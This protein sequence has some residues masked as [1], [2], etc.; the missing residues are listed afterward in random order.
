VG[1]EVVEAITGFFNSSSL[2]REVN[3][4]IISL[5]PK[6]VNPSAMGDFKPIACCNVIYK[7]ITRILSNRMLPFLS[8]LVS[9]NQFAFISARSISENVL[10]AQELVG[11]YHKEKGNPRCT[12]KI[13]FIK[14]YDFVN[15]EFILHCLHCF[16]FPKIFLG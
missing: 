11:G 1:Q 8:D 4:T 12:L 16:G 3:A 15:W 13:D 5:V 6:K 9:K 2:L 10:L 14:A 7:C